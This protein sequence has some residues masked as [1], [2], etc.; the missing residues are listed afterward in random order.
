[1][2]LHYDETALHHAEQLGVERHRLFESVKAY[3]AKI[4]N[5]YFSGK[6]VVLNSG[7]T[8]VEVKRILDAQDKAEAIRKQMEESRKK[9]EAALT[10]A[11]QAQKHELEALLAHLKTE[12]EAAQAKFPESKVSLV[13]PAAYEDLKKAYAEM[14]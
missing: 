5:G 11:Y 10:H 8:K 6:E 7:L 13:S 9:Y 4:K 2:P 3:K 12:Y 1:M 14:H